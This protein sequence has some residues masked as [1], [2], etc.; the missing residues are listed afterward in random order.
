MS[1]P[2]KLLIGL[3]LA[4]AAG[5]IGY[6]P[7]GQGAAFVDRTE[8]LAREQ[9]RL[10][11][12]AGVAVRLGRDPLSRTAHLSGPADDFQ[13]RGIGLLPGIDG[14]VGDVPGIGAVR[15]DDGGN[16]GNGG[17]GVPLLVETLGLAALVYLL[18]V[19]AGWV[20]FRPRRE[21][22]L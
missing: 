15:W 12:V 19:G 20:L 14:R 4:L 6:G 21:T 11:A 2:L 13:R 18:G 7:L 3:A 9:V 1:A 16:G 10:A 22:F 5:W 17:N 8:A